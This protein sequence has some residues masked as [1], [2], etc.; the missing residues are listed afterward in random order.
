MSFGCISSSRGGHFFRVCYDSNISPTYRRRPVGLWMSNSVWGMKHFALSDTLCPT[1]VSVLMFS[2]CRTLD[3]W[4]CAMAT[5]FLHY[6]TTRAQLGRVV[7]CFPF[8]LRFK[9]FSDILR[10]SGQTPDVR[11]C[12]MAVAFLYY[13]TTRAQLGRVFRCFSFHNISPFLLPDLF[14]LLPCLSN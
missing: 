9:Y 2:F 12:A 11:I 7:W 13:R 14:S 6:R 4:L 10:T 8:L 3:V 1:W 5:A